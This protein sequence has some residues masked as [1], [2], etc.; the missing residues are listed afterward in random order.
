[1]D[2]MSWGSPPQLIALDIDGTIMNGFR[3]MTDR[4]AAAVRNAVAAGAHVVLATGRPV[5]STLPVLGQL[6]LI[7]G[8]VLCSNGAVRMDVASGEFLTVHRFDAAP[9][10]HRLVELLPG[11]LFA[12][13]RPGLKN[14]VTGPFPLAEVAAELTVD[15][16]TL[17]AEP[18]SRLTVYWPER[19]AGELSARLLSERFAGAA[20][21]FDEGAPYLIAVRDGVSKGSALEDLRMELGVPAE[22]TLAVGDGGN[23]IEML[24]WAGRGVA[25]GHA[26]D[27]VKAVAG[28]VTGTIH[29]DGLAQ[30]LERW[31]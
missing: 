24:R 28:E 25:M 1:M 19:T 29:E 20:C 22:A 11:A 26:P 27:A 7:T 3:T 10:V 15:H 17:V 6:G 8:N 31:F 5:V 30:I 18:I 23:D 4:A 14:H 2:G 16:R 13:E 21:T 12:T 9:M